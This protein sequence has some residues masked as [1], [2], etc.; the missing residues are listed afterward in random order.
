MILKSSTTKT[1][2]TPGWC[3][4]YRLYISPISSVCPPSYVIRNFQCECTLTVSTSAKPTDHSCFLRSSSERCDHRQRMTYNTNERKSIRA[5]ALLLLMPLLNRWLDRFSA[6]SSSSLVRAFAPKVVPSFRSRRTKTMTNSITITV[7]DD[8]C[9]GQDMDQDALME[10]DMLVAVNEKDEL[11]PNAVLS[12]KEGHT[13]TSTT[14]RATLHRAFSFFLFNKENKLLLTQRAD[15]KITFPHVWTNTVCSHP[16]YGMTPNEADVVP[17]AYPAFPGIK[18][19]AIRKCQHELGI[20]RQY[21]PHG[22]IQFITR[23][24]YWAADT[25]TYGN[26]SPWGEHEIDYILFMKSKEETE[27]PIQAHKDEVSDYKYVSPAELRAMMQDPSLRWSPWFLGIMER[28]GWD[29]WEALDSGAL[30]GKFTND[31]ITYFDPPPQHVAQY[32][33]PEHT[34]LTGVLAVKSK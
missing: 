11:I 26:E 12:K 6:S 27:I 31:R 30:T 5:I 14:P 15:T 19:A 34:P 13:F 3:R 1:K 17:D 7:S 20:S 23:F 4:V 10:T 28:G 22:D 29:W 24:H 21:I 32:N 2:H 16:L 25:L 8:S 33:L 9:Y 18:H